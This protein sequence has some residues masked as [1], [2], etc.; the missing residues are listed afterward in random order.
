MLLLV[1]AW[2]M[3]NAAPVQG[4]GLGT[5]GNAV[6]VQGFICSRAVRV[7]QGAVCPRDGVSWHGLQSSDKAVK[8]LDPTFSACNLAAEGEGILQALSWR[9]GTLSALP[10]HAGLCWAMP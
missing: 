3:F 1:L 10:G 2:A 6:A 7:Q 8:A 5:G 9:R 4:K